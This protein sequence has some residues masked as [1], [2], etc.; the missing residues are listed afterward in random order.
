MLNT[1]N[2]DSINKLKEKLGLK[3]NVATNGDDTAVSS[4]TA[5]V[6]EQST[7]SLQEMSQPDAAADGELKPRRPRRKQMNELEKLQENLD[8]TF[9]RNEVLN[10]TGR[11][12]CTLE[13]NQRSAAAKK[14]VTPTKTKAKGAQKNVIDSDTSSGKKEISEKST[15]IVLHYFRAVK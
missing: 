14:P 7:E 10:A 4:S 8:S 5:P 11:R 6:I 15:F 12:A 9:I 2:D 13:Q 1:L 3:E